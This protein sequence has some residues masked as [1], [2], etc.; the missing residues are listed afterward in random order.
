M[1]SFNHPMVSIPKRSYEMAM[2]TLAAAAN[3]Q[4]RPFMDHDWIERVMNMLTIGGERMN[5]VTSEHVPK[6]AAYLVQDGNVTGMITGL[7]CEP[8]SPDGFAGDV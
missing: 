7:S 2:R 8:D 6:G 3:P 4:T 1:S 5:F